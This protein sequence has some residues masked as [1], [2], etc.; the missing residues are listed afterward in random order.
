MIICMLG[1]PQSFLLFIFS[2][3]LS[4]SL[5]LSLILQFRS[6]LSFTTFP[7]NR[8]QHKVNN[9]YYAVK[10]IQHDD[11]QDGPANSLKEEITSMKTLRE[12]PY[13]VRLHDVFYEHNR[14][15]LVME[16]MK[17]GDLLDKICEKITYNEDDAKKVTTSLLDAVRYCHKKNIA[18]RDIKPE[19]KCVFYY[20][21]FICAY[22]STVCCF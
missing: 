9:A 14:T 20:K 4:L 15:Y 18:H 16:E 19:S 11:Y 8:C 5:S 12:C 6:S 2:L 1:R 17:G 10:D 22:C 13:I 7:K 21:L 3:R